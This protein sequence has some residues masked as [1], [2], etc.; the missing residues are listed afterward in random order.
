MPGQ[1]DSEFKV[2]AEDKLC[3]KGRLEAGHHLKYAASI[4]GLF[5]HPHLYNSKWPVTRSQHR[6]RII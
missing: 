1:S 2:E 6:G 4:M 3:D 5:T